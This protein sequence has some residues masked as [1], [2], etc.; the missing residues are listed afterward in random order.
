MLSQRVH[1]AFKKKYPGLIAGVLPA[2]KFRHT[3]VSKMC[4]E[5]ALSKELRDLSFCSAVLIPG[6][7]KK[8]RKKYGIRKARTYKG[9]PH[10][11]H[12]KMFKNKYKDDKGKVRKCKCFVSGKEGHFAR[13]CK[14]KSGNIVRLAVY[15][16]LDIPKEWDI[17]SADS[18]DKS[19]VYS[20]SEGEGEFQAGIAIGKEE[21]MFMV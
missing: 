11:S 1:E 8:N 20:I 7:Y 2:I 5:A 15:Q 19:S 14:S 13:D 17:V 3:F 21:F 12:V 16:E 6:Y 9:K 18:S 10:G 4:K